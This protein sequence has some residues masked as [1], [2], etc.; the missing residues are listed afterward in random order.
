[1]KIPA[2]VSRQVEQIPRPFADDVRDFLAACRLA[3]DEDFIPL[4]RVPL[5][6]L[7]R[8][9]VMLARGR[10]PPAMRRYCPRLFQPRIEI[11]N[12]VRGGLGEFP[13]ETLFSAVAVYG[14]AIRQAI[15]ERVLRE[16][17]KRSVRR[18][19]KSKR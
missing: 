2:E 4:D 3:E 14:D 12:Q 18:W 8:W 19:Q 5:P 17:G 9:A 13:S 10:Y 7:H 6:Y 16:I 11:Q 1:M 15:A